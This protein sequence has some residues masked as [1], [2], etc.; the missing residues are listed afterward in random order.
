MALV[1]SSG[2]SQTW[3][4][5]EK[6]DGHTCSSVFSNGFFEGSF[7]GHGKNLTTAYAPSTCAFI[8]TIGWCLISGIKVMIL[9]SGVEQW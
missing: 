4:E 1:L 2:L 8:I 3:H 6:N 5:F 7:S 9:R